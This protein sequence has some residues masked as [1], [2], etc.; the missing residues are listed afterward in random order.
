MKQN[1]KHVHQRKKSDQVIVAV[2]L[3]DALMHR[4]R[5]LR[6]R[7]ERLGLLVGVHL[8]AK[9]MVDA[10]ASNERVKGGV[11]SLIGQHLSGS[12]G[13]PVLA[14]VAIVL[15]THDFDFRIEVGRNGRVIIDSTSND[16]FAYLGN[17]TINGKREPDDLADEIAL[18]VERAV[19]AAGG[20]Q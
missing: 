1:S 12:T 10:S 9:Y 19:L 13:D 18:I 2:H 16:G 15:G 4:M 5:G 7:W 20:A 6:A 8:H 14:D 3:I 11:Q 17:F